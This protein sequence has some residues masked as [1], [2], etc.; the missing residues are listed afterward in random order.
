MPMKTM[1]LKKKGL[2]LAHGKDWKY[3]SEFVFK[4]CYKLGKL[5]GKYIRI[6]KGI[7]LY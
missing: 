3:R 6:L 2:L 7:P 1:N 4:F 5:G